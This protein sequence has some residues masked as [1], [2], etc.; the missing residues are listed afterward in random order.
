MKSIVYRGA[1]DFVLEDKPEPRP[2]PR[3]VLLHPLFV[4][5]CFTDKHRYDGLVDGVGGMVGGHEFSAEVIEVGA[6]V[7]VLTPGQKVSVDPRIYCG[8]C[9]MCQA[10]LET[11]CMRGR[12]VVGVTAGHDGGLAELCVVPDYACYPLPEGVTPEAGACAEPLCCATRAV[13]R[14]GVRIGDNV[15]LFGGEDYNLFAARWLRSAG[16]NRVV[17]ADPLERRRSA[18]LEL[19]AHAALDARDEDVV[20]GVRE[21]MPAGADVVFVAFEDYVKESQL[22]LAQAFDACREQGVVVM[23]RAYSAVPYAN[24]THLAPWLKEVSLVQFGNFFGNEPAQGGRERGDW[25]V[26]LDALADGRVVAPVPGSH[27]VDFDDIRTKR[28]I[29]EIFGSLPHRHTK[30]LVELG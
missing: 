9:R 28:D 17:L 12:R 8:A 7:E 11:M 26:S 23:L 18:A 14:A 10:G 2:G 15:A 29:D 3:D 19:G 1:R 24:V 21:L 30:I 25:Q 6:E 5:L 20:A 13:R 4:G 16:A 27:V 22:Y